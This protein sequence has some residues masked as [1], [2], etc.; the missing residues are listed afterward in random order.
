MFLRQV[1][2]PKAGIQLKNFE[3]VE[4][5]EGTNF[6]YHLPVAI[7]LEC[8]M[9]QNMGQSKGKYNRERIYKRKERDGTMFNGIMEELV[10]LINP[11]VLPTDHTL[12]AVQ[13]AINAAAK[14][15]TPYKEIVPRKKKVN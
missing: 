2:T 12:K 3:I 7:L 4:D 13:I 11:E 1:S 10:E 15:S 6:S 5:Q 8:Q 14:A 9:E